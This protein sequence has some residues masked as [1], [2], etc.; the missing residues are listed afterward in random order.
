MSFAATDSK[1]RFFFFGFVFTAFL[2]SITFS[3]RYC[4]QKS[5]GLVF[6]QILVW[7]NTLKSQE[8]STKI[9]QRTLLSLIRMIKD[10]PWPLF[11]AY[12]RKTV[13]S[14]F[15]GKK[16]KSIAAHLNFHHNI[17]RSQNNILLI[18]ATLMTLSMQYLYSFC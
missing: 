18:S 4:S 2:T 3:F 12:H 8:V 16:K 6:L 11:K 1:L 7:F 17:I 15:K 14:V 10:T 5:P 13:F 9:N